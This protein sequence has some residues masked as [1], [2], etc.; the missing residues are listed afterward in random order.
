MTQVLS[1]PVAA[2]H[3]DEAAFR[4][5]YTAHF[6]PVSGYA[7]SLVGDTGLATDIAQEAFTRL[8][9]RWGS[10]RDPRAWVFFVATNLAT[11]TWRRA[12]RDRALTSALAPR[13]AFAEPAHD[14]WLRDLVDRLPAR[15]RD[16]TLL[17]YYA[18]LPL[19]EVARLTR[20]PLGTVKRRLHEGPRRTARRWRRF[21]TLPERP[22]LPLTPP[23]DG[24]DRALR[25]GRQRARRRRGGQAALT[26]AG[27][28]AVMAVVVAQGS[29]TPSADRLVPITDPAPTSTVAPGPSATAYPAT[30]PTTDPSP[31]GPAPS[32]TP[33][34]RSA[35]PAATAGAPAATAPSSQPYRAQALTRAYSPPIPAGARL[36]SGTL[37]SDDSGTRKTL[38]WCL[39]GSV[40]ETERGHRLRLQVCRDQTTDAAL[41]YARGLEADLVVRQ[42]GVERWRWSTRQAPAEAHQLATPAG[43]CW[44][45]TTDWPDVDGDGRRL[46]A[47]SYDFQATS[48]AQEV[49]EIPS[50]QSFPFTV[51]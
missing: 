32:V 35:T 38:D 36:C 44:S 1:G 50:T 47:G 16:V 46:A 9:A 37:T 24:L 39:Q 18:D 2:P 15:L 12:Q 51:S 13:T 17:H 7:L 8:Y 5:L 6:G 26:A 43:A 11:D 27:F 4:E 28:A 49:A 40:T 34:R 45:W 22:F 31:G 42:D 41:T 33:A 20:R 14:P 25:D 30:V 48:L 10:V 23:P 21:V 19:D 3:P 29:G